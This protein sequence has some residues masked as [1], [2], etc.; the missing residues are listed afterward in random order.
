MFT[1]NA[2]K[3]FMV[4][5]SLLSKILCV[6]AAMY[7]TEFVFV[8]FLH[9]YSKRLGFRELVLREARGYTRVKG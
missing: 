5:I 6:H 3:Y 4:K 8:F 7:T 9:K 1:V 2:N